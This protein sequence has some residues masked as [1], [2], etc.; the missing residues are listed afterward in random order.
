MKSKLKNKILPEMF[1]FY[2]TKYMYMHIVFVLLIFLIIFLLLL[3]Y[4]LYL[5]PHLPCPPYLPVRTT[6]ED[7]I[8]DCLCGCLPEYCC[9]FCC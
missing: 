5:F 3:L 4:Q 6:N 1:I 7:H 2:C 9:Y 8:V